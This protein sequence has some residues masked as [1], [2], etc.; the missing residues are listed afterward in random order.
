MG[1][2]ETQC[3]KQNKRAKGRDSTPESSANVPRGT[4]H[5][6]KSEMFHVEQWC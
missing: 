5:G 4:K 1:F 3:E 6:R 2:S